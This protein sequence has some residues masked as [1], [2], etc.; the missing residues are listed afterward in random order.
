MNRYHDT[1]PAH[2]AHKATLTGAAH[3]ASVERAWEA[4]AQEAQEQAKMA[5]V[6]SSPSADT[7]GQ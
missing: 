1:H 5:L 2:H 6:P 3:D 4:A 7:T